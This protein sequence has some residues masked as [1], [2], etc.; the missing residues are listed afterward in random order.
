MPPLPEECF[1]AA[2]NE[3]LSK[4][5]IMLNL[6]NGE[7]EQQIPATCLLFAGKEA[8]YSRSK[9]P[10]IY[11]FKVNNAYKGNARKAR[12][13]T[14]EM[15]RKLMKGLIRNAKNEMTSIK[16]SKISSRQ[17]QSLVV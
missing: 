7:V 2:G 14:R 16:S 17:L 4:D 8:D 1:I 12:L 11:F 15:K 3:L 10:I 6:M 5:N 13:K 9:Y